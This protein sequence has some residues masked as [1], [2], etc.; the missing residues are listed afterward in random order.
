VRDAD[1]EEELAR[2]RVELRVDIDEW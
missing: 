2:E 1:D